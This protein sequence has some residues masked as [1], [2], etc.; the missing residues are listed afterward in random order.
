[1]NLF[2]ILILAF[3]VIL[4]LSNAAA[5]VVT[6]YRDKKQKIYQESVNRFQE[7]C[8]DKVVMEIYNMEQR[9]KDINSRPRQVTDIALNIF[10]NH[11]E[12]KIEECF[13]LAECF[14]NM[15]KDFCG[16]VR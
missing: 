3:M 2:E 15:G 13:R 14:F 16:E 7:L 8:S 10:I 5:V 12:I 4:S 1:M 11:P 9:K 6:Y